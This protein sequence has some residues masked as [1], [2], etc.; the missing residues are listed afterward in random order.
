MG[1]DNLANHYK[2]NFGLMQHHKWSLSEMESMMPWERYIYI[3]L[4]Q[5]YLREQE[6]QMKDREAEMK[7]QMSTANRRR[8]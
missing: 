1:H 6:Q 7:A 8:L 5:D 4:L 2:T 3:D